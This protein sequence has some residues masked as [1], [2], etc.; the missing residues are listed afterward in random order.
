MTTRATNPLTD[1]ATST[2]QVGNALQTGDCLRVGDCLALLAEQPE[3]S[4]GLTVTSPPYDDLRRYDTPTPLDRLALGQALFRVTRPGG[5]CAVV[6]QDASHRYAKSLTSFRLALDWCDRAGWHLFETCIYHR[7]AAPGPWWRTRLRVDHEFVF[8]FVK[9]EKPRAFH[10]EAF[11][12]PTRHA[13]ERVSRKAYPRR[14]TPYLNRETPWGEPPPTVQPWQCRGTVWHYAASSAEGN[15]LKLEHP[16]TMPDALA[17]DLIAGFSDPGD[18][19]L[20]PLMGS[21]TTCVMAARLGRRFLGM[22]ASARYVQIARRRLEAE[23]KSENLAE[24]LCAE[25]LHREDFRAEGFR[26]AQ[27]A[28][29]VASG[30]RHE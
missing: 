30:D 27:E 20:D 6:I 21:G 15:R 11:L 10:K 23:A 16:A 5:V 13:G 28:L 24:D 3:E 19:V 9:G 12:I 7:H 17:G 18:L 26:H 25:D 4:V 2:P 1:C 8:L 29:E 14:G 22:D